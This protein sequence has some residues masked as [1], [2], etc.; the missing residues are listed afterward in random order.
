MVGWLMYNELKTT[1][2]RRVEAYLSYYPSIC[3]EGL[4]KIMNIHTPR[5]F[6]PRPATLYR[7]PTATFIN[8][9]CTVNITQ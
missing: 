6:H 5:V 2:E 3:P 9:A 4:R 1:W 7:A 8:Y